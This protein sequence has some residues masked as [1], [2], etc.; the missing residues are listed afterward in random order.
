MS[1]TNKHNETGASLMGTVVLAGLFSA[2][3]LAAVNLDRLQSRSL[4][5][6]KRQGEVEDLRNYLRR[7]FDCDQTMRRERAK[8]TLGAPIDLYDAAGT[9]LGTKVGQSIAFGRYRID[10]TCTPNSLGARISLRYKRDSETAPRELFKIPLEC[11]GCRPD[12]QMTDAEVQHIVTQN[13]HADGEFDPSFAGSRP[14]Q[15][16]DPP[17]AS[18]DVNDAPKRVRLIHQ[19][20]VITRISKYGD[21]VPAGDIWETSVHYDAAS[22]DRICRIFGYEESDFSRSSATEPRDE[23]RQGYTSEHNNWMIYWDPGA[24]RWSTRPA[25]NDNRWLA[26]VECLNPICR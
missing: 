9:R 10:A 3:L 19:S 20:M 5:L 11:K 23:H 1:L 8:C 4:A 13:L 21:G 7:R 17:S 22:A 14:V 12:F 25:Q 2:V 18:F 24:S 16:L 26:I 15:A 6:S